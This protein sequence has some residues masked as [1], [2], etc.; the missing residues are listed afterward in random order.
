MSSRSRHRAMPGLVLIAALGLIAAGAAYVWRGTGASATLPDGSERVRVTFTGGHETV[1]VD[2]G[3]PVKLIA[4]ALGVPDEVFR[5]A[6]SGVRPA[7]GRGP[8]G[9]EARRNKAALMAVLGPHGITNDR[10]DEVSNYYRYRPQAGELWPTDDAVAYAIV[11][12]RRITRFDIARGGSG[13]SSAPTASVPGM[14][15]V[16]IDVTL[17]FGPAFETNGSVTALAVA[18]VVD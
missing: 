15:D 12:D 2:R 6:F 14:E 5:K 1:A 9:E 17:A 3:R 11:K 13:Y 10:L 7:K 18:E 8:T 4:A 16:A